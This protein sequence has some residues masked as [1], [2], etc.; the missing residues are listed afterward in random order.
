M[1]THDEEPIVKVSD[2]GLSKL[3]DSQTMMKTF[4]GT[5]MY[6]APEILITGGRGSYT[7]QVDVWSLGVI[8]Y[9]CLSGLTPFRI[10]DKLHT[11]SDQIMKGLYNFNI[12]KFSHITP[13]AKDLVSPNST[14]NF[15][16]NHYKHSKKNFDF[17]D[18]K[19]DDS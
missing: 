8:L 11:L 3:V 1:A 16:S 14:L 5:P 17:S 7:C 13:E 15:F 19:N 4:C 10:H 18:K 2:F 9:C 6:V 12:P